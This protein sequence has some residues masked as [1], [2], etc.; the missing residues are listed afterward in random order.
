M[1][2]WTGRGLSE[3]ELWALHAVWQE[4]A[5][6]HPSHHILVFLLGLLDDLQGTG[7]VH[8]AQFGT[9]TASGTT[10]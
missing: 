3:E 6:G 4:P 9:D 10:C 1:P 2:T 7:K 5:G 8:S